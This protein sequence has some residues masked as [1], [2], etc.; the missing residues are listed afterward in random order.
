MYQDVKRRLPYD[1]SDIVD[2]FTYRTVA[3][4]IRIY[5]VKCMFATYASISMLTN[6]IPA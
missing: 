1:W 2:A 5:F 4:T 6:G 3:S